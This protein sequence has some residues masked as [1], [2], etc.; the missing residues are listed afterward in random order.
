MHRQDIFRSFPNLEK[1]RP[2]NDE[3]NEKGGGGKW[4]LH[5][6]LR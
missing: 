5:S 4:H 3:K 6:Q 2:K 1:D